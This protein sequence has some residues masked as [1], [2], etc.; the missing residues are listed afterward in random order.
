[1]NKVK[2][3][4]AK[5]QKALCKEAREVEKTALK[6]KKSPTNEDLRRLIILQHEEIMEAIN[7][8]R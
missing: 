2:F 4:I 3:S 6:E 5:S 8:H 1:M 7:E